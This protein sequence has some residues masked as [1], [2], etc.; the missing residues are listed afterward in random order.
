LCDQKGIP[1]GNKTVMIKRLQNYMRTYVGQ[2]SREEEAPPMPL[3]MWDDYND[4]Y[5]EVIVTTTEIA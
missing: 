1:T 3:S 2:P 4:E 5:K